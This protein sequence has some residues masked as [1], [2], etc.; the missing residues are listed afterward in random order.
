MKN[1]SRSLQYA[2]YVVPLVIFALAVSTRLWHYLHFYKQSLGSPLKYE[3]MAMARSFAR[4]GAFVDVF[5]PGTG[6]TAHSTP[7]YP[8]LVGAILKTLGD[9]SDGYTAIRMMTCLSAAT[10]YAMLPRIS[11]VLG[12]SWTAGA[13]GGLMGAL[14]P[15]RILEMTG[16][17][18]NV[19]ATMLFLVILLIFNRNVP[20]ERSSVFWPLL[21]GILAGCM[22]LFGASF[23]PAVFVALLEASHKRS[24]SLNLRFVFLAAIGLLAALSPWIIRNY[25]VF[26]S[27]IPL[28][29]NFWLEVA[30]S[31]Q[32]GASATFERNIRTKVHVT[33]HPN[34][35][36]VERARY[37]LI[38]ERAYM[39]EKRH[40]AL[41]WILANKL[42][43]LK[44]ALQ[45]FWS[46]WFFDFNGVYM[47]LFCWAVVLGGFG[48]IWISRA[49]LLRQR[50]LL[51]I[52]KLLLAFAIVHVFIE[53][54]ARYRYPIHV[55]LLVPCGFFCTRIAH[56]IWSKYLK[57]AAAGRF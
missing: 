16:D 40:Q 29:G 54:S 27:F 53:V 56:S 1:F 46:F 33:S 15:Y 9:D 41:Q 37:V 42:E 35:S 30:V 12:F 6:P 21:L 49:E 24:T 39:D 38:G 19:A 20:Y 43:F 52:V 51:Y 57:T 26:H 32:D 4:E 18:E 14:F 2:K 8:L 10:S 28:R 47:N 22:A 50:K 55:L 36:K 3:V 11:T 44:L 48:G 25:I 31:N 23:L 5:G 7:L 34:T 45:R 13:L 17:F